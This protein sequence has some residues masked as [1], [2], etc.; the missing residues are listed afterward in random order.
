V[1]V[2]YPVR[3]CL[4][5]GRSGRLFWESVG[6][7]V[8]GVDDYRIG[9]RIKIVERGEQMEGPDSETFHGQSASAT[10]FWKGLPGPGSSEEG[11]CRSEIVLPEQWAALVVE[12]VCDVVFDRRT[13][14]DG[15]GH[16]SIARRRRCSSSSS[17]MRSNASTGKA[18]SGT[19]LS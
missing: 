5:L 13:D 18:S 6:P 19:I 10:V 11:E 8:D 17:G 9:P 12:L 16:L 1:A 14:P 2:V 3:D 15:S 7:D 4:A